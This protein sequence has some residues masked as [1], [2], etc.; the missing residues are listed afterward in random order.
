[1]TKPLSRA[2]R[3][4]HVR[5]DNMVYFISASTFNHARY[6]TPVSHKILLQEELF[7]VASLHGITIEAWVILDNHYHLLFQLEHG[8][9]LASFFKQL[10]GR[11]ARMFNDK[12]RVKGRTVWYNYWDKCV[13]SEEDY[14]GKFNYLHYNPI[15]HGYVQRLHDWPFS[16]FWFY[17]ETKG[18]EWLNEC[19]RSYPIKDFRVGE[20]DLF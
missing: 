3:P 1:M 5:L 16:S 11:T 6:L 12:D 18:L 2:K 9:N 14:W 20:D 17:L 19:W 10:H 15:K 8:Q 4:H 7:T 13:N